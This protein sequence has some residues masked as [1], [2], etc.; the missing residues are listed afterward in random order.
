[1]SWLAFL[2]YESKDDDELGA[3]SGLIH[4]FSQRSRVDVLMQKLRLSRASKK[5]KIPGRKRERALMTVL[6]YPSILSTIVSHEDGS[7]RK[8]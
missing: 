4:L 5:K 2:L 7:F 1:M 6:V 3:L 8:F